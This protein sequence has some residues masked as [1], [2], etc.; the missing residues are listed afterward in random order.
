MINF[1]E[2]FKNHQATR[3]GQERNNRYRFIKTS[4]RR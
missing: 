3:S 1:D 4:Y 2:L